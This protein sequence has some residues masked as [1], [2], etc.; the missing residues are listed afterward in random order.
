M[1]YF[2][3]LKADG[4]KSNY[5]GGVKP[6]PAEKGDVGYLKCVSINQMDRYFGFQRLKNDNDAQ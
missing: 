6:A 1:Q 4:A 5:R 2:S 3:T